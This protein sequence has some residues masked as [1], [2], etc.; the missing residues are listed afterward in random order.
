MVRQEKPEY[1]Q[2]YYLEHKE[3]IAE[4]RKKKYWGDEEHRQEL[5]RKNREVRK[6][7]AGPSPKEV[8]RLF[9]T[10]GKKIRLFTTGRT[11][12]LVGVQKRKF[13]RLLKTGKIP[14]TPYVW[15]SIRYFSARQVDAI[16]EVFKAEMPREDLKDAIKKKW[17]ELG[18]PRL[19]EITPFR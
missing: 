8:G 14:T 9:L 2:T 16:K 10:H 4:K 17:D 5:L 13:G 1:Q 6:A 15:G 7:S 12:E 18:V 3:E 11:A 19:P